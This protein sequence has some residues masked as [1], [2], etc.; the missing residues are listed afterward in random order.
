MGGPESDEP[1]RNT[2]IFCGHS[3]MREWNRIIN[4]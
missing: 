3:W 1:L 4:P 2:A